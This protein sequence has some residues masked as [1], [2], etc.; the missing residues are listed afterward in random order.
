M[1][2]KSF[3]F[4]DLMALFYHFWCPLMPVLSVG[5]FM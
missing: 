1:S 2:G 3:H 5:S 4:L